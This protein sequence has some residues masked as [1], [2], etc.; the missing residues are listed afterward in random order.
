[1]DYACGIN[2][3]SL[4]KGVDNQAWYYTGGMTS[5]ACNIDAA[6]NQAFDLLTLLAGD[7]T[8][9][10]TYSDGYVTAMLALIAPLCSTARVITLLGAAW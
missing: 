7:W 8:T 5:T 9:V 1:M 4:F 6:L 10:Y 3:S 2:E